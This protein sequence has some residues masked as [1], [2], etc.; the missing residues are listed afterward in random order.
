MPV[1]MFG[2]DFSEGKGWGVR[3]TDRDRDRQTDRQRLRGAPEG[4]GRWCGGGGV[5]WRVS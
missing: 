3:Q 2:V 5:G 1:V 4:G